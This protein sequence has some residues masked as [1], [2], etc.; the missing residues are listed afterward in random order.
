MKRVKAVILV[1]ILVMGLGSRVQGLAAGMVWPPE[2]IYVKGYDR[3]SYEAY[4]MIGSPMKLSTEM[5]A[6]V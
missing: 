2:E 6:P 5:M 4:H 1:G 3:F